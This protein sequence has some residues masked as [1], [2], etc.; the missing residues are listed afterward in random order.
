MSDLTPDAQIQA[1]LKRLMHDP[2]CPAVDVMSTRSLAARSKD[3]TCT[4]GV[5][6]L[7]AL[8]QRVRELEERDYNERQRAD[9]LAAQVQQLRGA[10][11]RLID[12]NRLMRLIAEDRF[13]DS[14]VQD[15][16]RAALRATEPR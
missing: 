1:A 5:A 12:E 3:F 11:M 10:L 2:S 4:C 13:A 14:A 9:R 16:A 6:G 15:I 7:A 8:V